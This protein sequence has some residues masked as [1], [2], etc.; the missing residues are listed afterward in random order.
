[1]VPLFIEENIL[2]SKDASDLKFYSDYSRYCD[3]KQKKENWDES[4]DRV[5]G[6]HR[7]KYKDV[8]TPELEKLL[9]FTEVAYKEKLFLGSQRALQFG[10]D[11]ILKHNSKMFNC[12]SSWCDRNEFFQ[13]AMYWLLSGCGIGFSVQWHHVDKLST[14][15][16]REEGVK[17]Y[18]VPDSIEGWS[19]SFG[20]LFSSYFDTDPTFP[21]YQGHRVDFDLSEIRPKGAMIAGGFKAPGPDGLREAL[22]KCDSLLA[23]V[24]ENHNGKLRPIDAYDFLMH[25]SDAVLSG[26]VRRS[27]TICLF[28]KDDKDMLNAKTGDWYISNPQ[29]ARSNNSVI[30]VRNEVTREEFSEIMKSVKDFGE[31]GFIWVDDKNICFNPCV[32]IGMW[33]QTVK[34]VSGW[35][36]CNLVEGN[37][38]MC[39]TPELFYR[40]CKAAAILGTLQAG[41]TDFKYV[42]PASKEIFDREALLGVSFTGWVNNPDVMLDPEIQKEGARIV[43]KWNKIVANIIGINQSARTTCCKPSGNA[44]VI[45]GSASGIHGEHSKHYI[46]NMQMNKEDDVAKIFA[47]INPEAVEDSVWSANGTDW[48]FSIPITA[49]DG[50]IYKKD[51]LGTKQLDIVKLTQ[52]NWIE[53]GTN[54]ELCVNPLVRHNVSNTISV[55]DWDEVEEY[56]YQNRAWF[57]G[58][59]L[60]SISGD[61]DY[62][63]APFTE[64]L[65]ADE[66][67]A[68]YGDAAVLASGLVVD[69]LS[70]FGDLWVAC[71]SAQGFGEDLSGTN[72]SNL[73]KKDWVRRCKQFSERYLQDD[74]ILAT[75]CLKD[76]YLLHK[77]LKLTRESV[78]INWEDYDLEPNYADANTLG[79][80]ACSNGQCEIPT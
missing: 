20:V 12:L 62:N 17:T 18:V 59:S 21:D 13:E 5:M 8:L 76:V 67:L 32:E 68:K 39:T 49:K 75:Y 29:R 19:D 34:L 41:F 73:L 3:E 37:G 53:E 4:V 2:G 70:A 23:N 7:G 40:A 45:L 44:S 9:S 63:Q 38:N 60:L 79:A 35:Q 42:S 43:K 66:L 33:P 46:R 1:M 27:A 58:I 30:L 69:A 78:S 71:S 6:M 74:L 31:P 55:N 77:W 15:S 11:P 28:S 50:S 36:G 61:K 48:V 65:M 10:G 72:H 52:Q 56:I 51:L 57:A 25:M 64:V 16:S 14:I 26:G 47:D 54:V 22:I 80:V 24:V